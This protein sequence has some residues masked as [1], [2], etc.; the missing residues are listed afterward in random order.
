MSDRTPLEDVVRRAFDANLRY[1][2]TVGRATSDYVQTVSKLWA[3]APVSW[4][5]GLRSRPTTAGAT[6]PREEAA[7]VPSLLLQGPA[8]TTAQAVVMISNDLDREAEAPV[9]ASALRGPGGGTIPNKLR[10]RP[11]SVNLPAGTRVPVT[12]MVNITKSLQEGAAYHGSID[13]PGLSTLGVP[14]VV[15]RRER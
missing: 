3:D 11:E 7:P 5:P 8:G 10:T 13:V 15:R 14:V 12:V 2:E 1:W 9:V 6:A 4:M